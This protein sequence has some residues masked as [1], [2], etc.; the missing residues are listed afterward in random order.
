[1]T[2]E[3]FVIS[4]VVYHAASY[5]VMLESEQNQTA[6]DVQELSVNET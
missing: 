2:T 5:C 6:A 3:D 4:W 1:M